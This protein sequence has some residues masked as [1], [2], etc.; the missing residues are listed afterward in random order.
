[1]EDS[2]LESDVV[3]VDMK[4]I[5][6]RNAQKASIRYKSKNDRRSPAIDS[7]IDS[8]H[9]TKLDNS[10]Q[11]HTSGAATSLGLSVGGVDQHLSNRLIKGGV[12][13]PEDFG[14]MVPKHNYSQLTSDSKLELHSM[15]KKVPGKGIFSSLH[16]NTG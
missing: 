5:S 10:R 9:V 8:R 3:T 7:T 15:R 14:A 4:R 6:P 16:F 1:M 13:A 12:Y 11:K 2:I